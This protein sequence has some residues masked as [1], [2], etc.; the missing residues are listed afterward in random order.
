MNEVAKDNLRDFIGDY[1][2]NSILQVMVEYCADHHKFAME[3]K[4]PDSK[5]LGKQHLYAAHRLEEVLVK[6]RECGPGSG[7]R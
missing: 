4:D 1:G 6:L 3:R 5:K 2:L 7:C